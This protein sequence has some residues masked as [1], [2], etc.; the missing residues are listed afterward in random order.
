[1]YTYFS[2]HY[3]TLMCFYDI[4]NYISS[5]YTIW[6]FNNY[7]W[8]KKRLLENISIKFSKIT[9]IWMNVIFWNKFIQ[10]FFMTKWNN[11]SNFCSLCRFYS[12]GGENLQPQRNLLDQ[13]LY[14]LQQ[15]DIWW[16]LAFQVFSRHQK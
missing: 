10:I 11:H 9:N 16:D 3:N 12:M 13:D 15:E 8:L 1:M 7:S 5:F 6:Y 14:A 4:L 2:H